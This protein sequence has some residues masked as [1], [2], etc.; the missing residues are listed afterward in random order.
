VLAKSTVIFIAQY[1]RQLMGKFQTGLMSITETAIAMITELKTWRQWTVPS[2]IACTAKQ[3]RG[4]LAEPQQKSCLKGQFL[5]P[6]HG[7]QRLMG[8]D[9]TASMPRNLLQNASHSPET[10]SSVRLSISQKHITQ[11]FAQVN[12]KASHVAPPRQAQCRS[13]VRTAASLLRI[14]A[15]RI[16]PKLVR[17]DAIKIRLISCETFETE[18]CEPVYDL[19]I[20]V[21]HCYYANG[22]LVSN[23]DGVRTMAEAER[24]GLIHS[25][26]GQ[27]TSTRRRSDVQDTN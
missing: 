7:T 25:G 10:A 23:C 24:L 2:I 12:A 26:S 9:G 16:A 11:F 17:A 18:N 5:R 8:K 22:I 27:S 13:Y 4:S 21:D 20:E 1:G 3:I 19:T 6:V 15:E 14:I